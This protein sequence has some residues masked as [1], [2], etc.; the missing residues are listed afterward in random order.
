MA[1]QDEPNLP[2]SNRENRK[3]ADLLPRFYRTDSNKKFLSATLD[4][5]TQPGTVKKITGF[6][7]RQSAK[8]VKSSDVFLSASD[9]T[10]QDYQLEP[11]AVIQDYLGNTTFFKDYIDHINHISVAGG[12][13]NNHERLNKQEFYSWN[14]H[15]SWDKFV[16]FQQYYWLP[17]GP[18]PIEVEG[19]QLDIESTY[20]VI[21]ED[22]GDTYAY[23]FSPDGLT[24]NPALTL[25]RGQTYHFS[26]D[27]PNNPFSI[28]TARTPGELDR[29][30]EG[31]SSSAI[32]TGTLT[33]KV[34]NDSPDVLFYVSEQD[35]NV[36][37]VLQV[38]DIDENS[39]LNLE[40]DI[41]GKKTYTMNNGVPLSNGMKLFF[42]GN[43]TPEKYS[44]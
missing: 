11:S 20:T 14:P 7:G 29:Y 24:R 36:G 41:I 22:E 30:T 37:G 43:I 35:P 38:K 12:I 8:S 15:I 17:Y 39:F 2:L 21:A 42:K 3:S 13:V 5:L 25:Y 34:G 32:E 6:I 19:Q 31:V 16:N 26:I 44:S 23:I 40:T 27:T 28:K 18:A 10:R 9:K 4:Q 33:F 1:N